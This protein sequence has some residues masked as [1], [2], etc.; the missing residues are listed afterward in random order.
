MSDAQGAAK[1]TDCPICNKIVEDTDK[2]VGCDL[3]GTW[4]H[5]NCVNVNQNLYKSLTNC[6][7]HALAWYCR[8]CRKVTLP[9]YKQMMEMKAKQVKLE[10]RVGK[11][12]EGQVTKDSVPALIKQAFQEPEVRMTVGELVKDSM[13]TGGAPVGAPNE[14]S[15]TSYAAARLAYEDRMNEEKR[16][17]NIII[18]RLP[19]STEEEKE[20]QQKED[21]QRI[22]DIIK[23]MDTDFMEDNMEEFKRLGNKQED[24]N[25]PILVRL[26]ANYRK[27]KIMENL[28]KLKDSTH[29]VSITHDLPKGLRA[30]HKTL[31]DKARQEKGDEAGN[32]HYRVTG[33]PGM[34]RVQSK[35]KK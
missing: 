5:S 26:K 34:E 6:K 4:Y 32:F 3:C 35:E 22:T 33:A 9:L 29:N 23:T 27:G 17:Q 12:E 19:E 21:K 16:K 2:G 18:H 15:S 8:D 11:L 30:Y 28:K 10:E 13:K 7:D 25:R 24:R 14:A 31:I 1:K 20:E